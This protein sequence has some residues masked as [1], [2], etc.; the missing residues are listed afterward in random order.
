MGEASILIKACSSFFMVMAGGMPCG[1]MC[2]TLGQD[3]PQVKA[4]NIKSHLPLAIL[5]LLSIFSAILLTSD[6]VC[7]LG[8]CKWIYS[9]FLL[10]PYYC[11]KQEKKTSFIDQRSWNCFWLKPN[12]GLCN[13]SFVLEIFHVPADTSHC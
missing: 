10:L 7:E 5:S 4:I 1:R 13:L 3:F 9:F 12:I 2:S 6:W 11:Y 8:L